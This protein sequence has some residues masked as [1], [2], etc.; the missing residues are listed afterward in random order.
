MGGVSV[1]LG[2]AAKPAG[3]YFCI[4]GPDSRP[5]LP[6]VKM[7]V[8]CSRPVVPALQYLRATHVCAFT[9]R[10]RDLRLLG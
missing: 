1:R 6:W 7:P 4:A 10:A 8:D 5:R 9:N 3:V 2:A